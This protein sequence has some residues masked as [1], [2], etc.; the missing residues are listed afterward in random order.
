M[1]A[2]CARPQL[3]YFELLSRSVHGKHTSNLDVVSLLA[4]VAKQSCSAPTLPYGVQAA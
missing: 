1:L 4:A 3:N 2:K